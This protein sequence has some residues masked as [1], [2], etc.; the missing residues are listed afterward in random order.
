MS[1]STKALSITI[2]CFIGC[3]YLAYYA[4]CRLAKCLY[5]ECNYVKCRYAECN[6]VECRYAEWHYAKYFYTECRHAKCLYAVLFLLNVLMLSFIMLSDVAP[7]MGESEN[8]GPYKMTW[9]QFYKTFYVRNLRA[10]VLS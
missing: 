4:E 8:A 7:S 3:R 1:L 5:A 6:Y 9:A 2:K 10:F